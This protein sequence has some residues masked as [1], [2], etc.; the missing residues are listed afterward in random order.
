MKKQLNMDEGKAA[1]IVEDTIDRLNQP[2][3]PTR[4]PLTDAI[5]EAN[6]AMLT[7][8]PK[9]KTPTRKVVYIEGVGAVDGAERETGAAATTYNS[10]K[11]LKSRGL[12]CHSTQADEF[13]EMYK[14]HEIQGVDVAPDGTHYFTSRKA[15]KQVMKV[16]GVHDHN[17]G[18]G[19]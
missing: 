18:Y 13:R 14:Q 8:K 7:A 5:R 15:R 4:V 3:E 17:G 16:R 6:M 9:P 12:S 11:P 1:Q 19:D 10:G 2:E